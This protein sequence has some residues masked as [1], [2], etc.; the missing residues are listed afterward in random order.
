MIATASRDQAAALHEVNGSVNQMDQ[1]TQQNA[2]MVDQ[3][4]SASRRTRQPGRYADDAGR[5]VPPGARL[6]RPPGRPRPPDGYYV[7]AESPAALDAGL[8]IRVAASPDKA[9]A[10]RWTSCWTA[11]CGR[12]PPGIHAVCARPSPASPS[13]K[14]FPSSPASQLPFRHRKTVAGPGSCRT[15]SSFLG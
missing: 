10:L 11:G 2:T 14:P 15:L 8:S 3:A 4:T 13:I 9:A 12:S 7:N 5:T 6:H 1:M